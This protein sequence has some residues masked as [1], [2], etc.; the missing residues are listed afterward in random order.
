M[1]R[2]PDSLQLCVSTCSCVCVC[3]CACLKVAKRTRTK[4][5]SWPMC[6]HSWLGEQ[7]TSEREPWFVIQIKFNGT[8]PTT[9]T[10]TTTTTTTRTENQMSYNNCCSC[11]NLSINILPGLPGCQG[12]QSTRVVVS[13]C[14]QR[15]PNVISCCLIVGEAVRLWGMLSGRILNQKLYII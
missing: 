15:C 4:S 9:T 7:T 5:D 6:N 11:C 1:A 14:C 2:F 12:R 13:R 10:A 3:V 8:I